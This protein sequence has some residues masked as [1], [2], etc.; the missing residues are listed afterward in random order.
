MLKKISLYV[1]PI[2]TVFTFL[3]LAESVIQH[4]SD[5][6]R[7]RIAAQE[8]DLLPLQVA[9][10]SLNVGDRPL[11]VSRI[12]VMIENVTQVKVEKS[13]TWRK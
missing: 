2:Q 10:R 4:C 11:Q 13:N 12:L 5:C 3:L 6:E 9:Q 8:C 1:I 7:S